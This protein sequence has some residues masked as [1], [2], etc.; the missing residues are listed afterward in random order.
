MTPEIISI[1]SLF[2]SIFTRPTW[3]KIQPLFI[4][5]ILCRGARRV[6]SIL[7][8]MGLGG[9]RSFSK[10]H[11]VFNQAQWSG[12][13]LSKILLGLLI[14]CLPKSWPILVAVD[15]TLERRR[16]RKITAKGMYRDAVRS[17]QSHVVTCM[18]LKWEVMT[19]I[20]PLPWSKRPW[21]L[22]LLTVL[23]PS[24]QANEKAGKRHKDMPNGKACCTLA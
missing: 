10:Y 19:L 13:A 22:P 11:W 17:S 5:A 15:E 21:A 4:G 12:L 7:R 2:S 6:S 8:V 23:A 14:R 18:G 20:V 16:G 1:L 3:K 24:K 9:E